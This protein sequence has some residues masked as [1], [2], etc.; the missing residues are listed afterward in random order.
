MRATR[1]TLGHSLSGMKVAS[2][3]WI[4]PVAFSSIRLQPF[5]ASMIPKTFR[6]SLNSSGGRMIAISGSRPTM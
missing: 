5:Q 4:L 1:M 2:S 3:G 6:N